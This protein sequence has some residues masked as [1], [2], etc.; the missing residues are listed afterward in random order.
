MTKDW[1]EKYGEVDAAFVNWTIGGVTD[2]KLAEYL[3]TLSTGA[4]ENS[5]IHHRE[6]IRGMT[7]NHIQTSRMTR[8]LDARNR[9]LTIMIIILAIITILVELAAHVHFRL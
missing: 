3:Q 9:I 8:K 1:T 6:I 2:E 5:R 7:I 4:I